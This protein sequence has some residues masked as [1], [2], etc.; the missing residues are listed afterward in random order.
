MS[1]RLNRR[2][3]T[4][5]ELMVVVAII[6]ILAS[7]AIP[8]FNKFQ[9][10]SKQSE[11]RANLKAVFTA[12]RAFFQEKDRFSPVVTEIGFSPERGNRYAYRLSA[13]GPLE[14]R[15]VPVPLPGAYVGVSV[16]TFK[17][18]P[19]APNPAS[20]MGRVAPNGGVEGLYL[21]GVKFHFLASATGD[22][23]R[24]FIENDTWW[25]SS[26]TTMA[27]ASP[28]TA[29]AFETVAGGEPFNSHNDVTCDP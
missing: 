5:I 16:D 23:D 27:H 24:D 21:N 11:A 19:A 18:F 9:A 6:G 28:C 8:N 14:D 20:E 17:Y 12:Q 26:E 22:I 10:R 4:L 2:G 13:G 1:K 15:F 29:A 7:I 25:V 3:F